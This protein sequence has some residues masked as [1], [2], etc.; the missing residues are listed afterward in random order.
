[1]IFKFVEMLYQMYGDGYEDAI[2]CFADTIFYEGQQDLSLDELFVEW[3]NYLKS[4]H[5]VKSA[6]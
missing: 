3:A 2:E 1:M 4:A 6:L 5:S